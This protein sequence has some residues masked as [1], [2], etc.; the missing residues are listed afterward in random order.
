MRGDKTDVSA[1]WLEEQ[2][3]LVTNR[4]QKEKVETNKT[5]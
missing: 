4:Q 5:K 3:L 1:E 2:W